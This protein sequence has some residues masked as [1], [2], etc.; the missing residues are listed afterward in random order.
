MAKRRQR[1]WA[2][3][4]LRKALRRPRITARGP[5]RPVVKQEP[6]L[7]Y[8]GPHTSK[9]ERILAREL[10]QRGIRWIPQVQVAGGRK[11]LGGMVVDFL[12]VDFRI[13]LRPH[14]EYWHGSTTARARDDLQ[15]LLLE[16]GGYRVVDIWEG[17][18]LRDVKTALDGAIGRLP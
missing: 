3:P 5:R 8:L 2:T 10:T 16:A 13:W 7:P 14:G 6:D 17:D 18:I 9:L 1:T 4:W 11:M 15:K 12:L